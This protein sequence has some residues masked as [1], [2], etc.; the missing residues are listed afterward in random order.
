MHSGKG[1]TMCYSLNHHEFST[2]MAAFQLIK[3]KPL[4]TNLI[5][6]LSK[7]YGRASH[8]KKEQASSP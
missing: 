3:K 2:L 7:Q 4:K 1:K 6:I 5:L 8:R